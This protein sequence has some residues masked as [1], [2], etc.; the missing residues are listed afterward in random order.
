VPILPRDVKKALDLL[1][2]DPARERSIDELAA[3]C[4]V[5]RR[6]L[7]KHFRRFVGRTP[8]D[9]QRRLRLKQ[10]RRELLRARPEASVTEIAV[11]CGVKHLGRFA[12][13]Y[14]EF[15]GESPSAT[16]QLRRQALAR[17]ESLRKI[18]S[19]A[20]ERPVIGVHP[21]AFLGATAHRAATMADEISAALLRSRWLSVGS[22]VNARYQLRGKVRDDGMSRLRVLVLL[23][24]AATG[25][26]LWADRWDGE[27]DDVFAF[28]ERVATRV[29]AAVERALR[30][31]EIERVRRKE[32]GEL[33]AWELTM[34]ALPQAMLIAPASQARALELLER[35]VELAPHDALPLALAAWCHAQRGGHSL[36]RRPDIEKQRA[37]E[38]ASR[39][40]RLNACDPL[41]ESLLGAARTLAGDLAAAAAH[42]DRALALDGG[43]AWA[44]NRR[45]LLAV[46]VGQPAD[47]IECFHIAR[48]LGPDDPL[49]FYCSIGIASAHFEV[50]RYHEAARWF[51]RGLTE[52]P[53]AVWA[54]RFRAPA[55]LLAGHKEE[56][57]RSFADLTRTYP[58]LTI[59]EVRS[60]LPFTPSFCD[61]ASEG[62]S[63]LGMSA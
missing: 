40:G 48:S 57:R 8:T 13:A 62:L 1:K 25:R 21:F 24:D 51:A 54:N 5:A 36:T 32:P 11:R 9:V 14:R 10:V 55:L 46:Y 7:Q 37:R 12:A 47:A 23:T 26:H 2:A 31:A 17:R 6:T 3:A 59:A 52:H 42:I 58:H 39:A 19:P 15:Y 22:P 63:S 49:N 35:A 27:A 18:L 43:C 20:V 28:E 44:W 45:G 29:A 33:D 38:L 60:A 61:R 53:Q 30:T 41:T 50:G 4:G 56:A 16:I 34:M